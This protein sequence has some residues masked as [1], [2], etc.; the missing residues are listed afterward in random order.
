[1]VVEGVEYLFR[2]RN[3]RLEAVVREAGAEERRGSPVRG[4]RSTG[5]ST[6]SSAVS[7]ARIVRDVQGAVTRLELAS[8][9]FERRP[10]PMARPS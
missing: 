10:Q 6:G 2:Y 5:P 9:P 4:T 3:R 1:M 7:S 8:Y